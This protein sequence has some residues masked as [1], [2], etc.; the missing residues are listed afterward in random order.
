MIWIQFNKLHNNL[1]I[2][3]RLMIREMDM[4]FST[5]SF[6]STILC[7]AVTLQEW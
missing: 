3:L 6:F 2:E 4:T 5:S 1:A 7:H